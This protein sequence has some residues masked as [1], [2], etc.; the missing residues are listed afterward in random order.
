MTTNNTKKRMVL[1]SAMIL[2]M[3]LAGF[4]F[5]NQTV[6]SFILDINPSV[7]VETNRMNKVKKITALNEDGKKLLEGYDAKGKSMDQTVEE[8]VDRLI[9]QGYLHKT[10]DNNILIS[11]NTEGLD[12][13]TLTKLQDIIDRLTTER[14]FKTKVTG[15]VL[16]KDD[17]VSKEAES[18]GVSIGKLSLIHNIIEKDPLKTVNQLKDRSIR[19]LKDMED[20]LD[21]DDDDQNLSGQRTEQSNLETHEVAVPKNEENN[22]VPAIMND[23]DGDDDD[24]GNDDYDDDDY[25]DYDDDDDDDDYDDDDDDDY[26][27]DDDDDDED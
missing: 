21:D 25:D 13:K 8:L 24:Y 3:A 6:S 10:N 26:D 19:D 23:D 7:Q 11:G 1:G 16:G 12:D 15:V 17:K 4:A 9:L 22:K 18:L 20:D 14:Q 27:D 5:M 2:L